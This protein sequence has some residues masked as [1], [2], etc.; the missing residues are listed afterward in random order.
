MFD[1]GNWK[2]ENLD[3][4]CASNLYIINSVQGRNDI[5][6]NVEK[7]L[8]ID[9]NEGK[10]EKYA[11]ANSV[12]SIIK[13]MGL[14]SLSI[15]ILHMNDIGSIG[16]DKKYDYVCFFNE[17]NCDKG[18]SHGDRLQKTNYYI[19]I[20]N[21]LKN[22]AFMRNLLLV[23]Q[24]NNI[25]I[26]F[27]PAPIYEKSLMQ[28]QAKKKNNSYWCRWDLFCEI[29]KKDALMDSREELDKAA[30]DAGCLSAVVMSDIYAGIQWNNYDY[31]LNEVVKQ[32]RK[33]SLAVEYADMKSQIKHNCFDLIK[34]VQ[35]NARVA[36]YG[37]GEVAKI[38]TEFLMQ[39]VLEID[40]YIV[41]DGYRK[42]QSYN[43][44][45]VFEISEIEPDENMGIVVALDKKNAKEVMGNLK[46]HGFC[47]V[48]YME[49]EFGV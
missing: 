6:N 39:R 29:R 18:G 3:M 14:F 15:D 19:V 10:G 24:E 25:G 2:L 46:E 33:M 37:I 49:N 34:F 43:G 22:D 4:F 11:E 20:E 13:N 9:G 44:K 35:G 26:A 41:S 30:K 17:K 16:P 31:M 5:M 32:I 1:A 45:A 27:S 42:E 47:R 48:F 28:E 23:M 38:V 8:L 12:E 36:V 21:L 7:L 40:F